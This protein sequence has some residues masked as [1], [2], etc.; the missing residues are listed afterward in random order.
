MEKEKLKLGYKNM[1]MKTKKLL[2]TAIVLFFISLVTYHFEHRRGVE[3]VSGTEF[4][5]GLDISKVERVLLKGKDQKELDLVKDGNIFVLANHGSFPV[6]TLKIN[7]FL[8]KI[9][10]I[11]IA[12]KVSDSA[13]S[14]DSYGVA[15]NQAEAT[16]A[17]FGKDN[18]KLVE[19]LVGSKNKNSGNYIRTSG[20]VE[21]FVTN[22]PLSVETTRDFF[23]DKTV[24]ASKSD[25][26]SSINVTNRSGKFSITNID[27]KFVLTGGDP[28]KVDDSKIEEFV[29]AFENISFSDFF[30]ASDARVQNIIFDNRYEIQNSN[31]LTYVMELGT[32]SAS[33]KERKYY[34]KVSSNIADLPAQVELKKDASKEE[35]EKLNSMLLSR[36][37]MAVF[38]N[39]NIRWIYELTEYKFKLLAKN[40]KDFFKM[41]P[42]KEKIKK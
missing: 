40:S 20:S 22:Q 37:Q 36:D 42:E 8:Y 21:T 35:L 6:D 38:N 29:R 27:K 31:M 13:K 41:A 3:V 12:E 26:V 30:E 18:K 14:Y 19:F 17:L 28:A 11:Q 33:E 39:K 25:S 7:E 15:E 34:F 1:S 24:L 2:I 9:S 4:I 16:V 10:D 5:K 32:N 23:I